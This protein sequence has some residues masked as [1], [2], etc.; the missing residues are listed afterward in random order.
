MTVTCST[1]VC[2]FGK[3]VVEKVEVSWP[4]CAGTF[5]WGGL[6]P[7]FKSKRLLLLCLLPLPALH[8]WRRQNDLKA[9]ERKK[10]RSNPCHPPWP[11]EVSPALASGSVQQEALRREGGWVE[12]VRDRSCYPGL[13]YLPCYP[14]TPKFKC[15]SRHLDNNQGGLQLIGSC[16]LKPTWLPWWL[17]W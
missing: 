7:S 13:I 12:S 10:A 3:Q 4:L 1:K 6:S 15:T 16:L 17:R 9:T 11:P 2:S 14:P 5:I 8:Y